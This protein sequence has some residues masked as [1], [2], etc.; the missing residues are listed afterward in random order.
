M[1]IRYDFAS[2]EKRLK[3][4]LQITEDQELAAC[5]GIQKSTYTGRKKRKSLPLTEI[6]LLCKSRQISLDW[7]FDN[8]VSAIPSTIIG[9]NATNVSIGDHSPIVIGTS[10]HTTAGEFADIIRDLPYAS[11]PFLNALRDRLRKFRELAKF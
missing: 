1:G 4:K 2:V 6:I 10:E 3:S 9:D 8:Q 11:K 7:L 5:L